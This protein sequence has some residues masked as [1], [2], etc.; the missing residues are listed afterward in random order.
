V[1]PSTGEELGQFVLDCLFN[2]FS[3]DY[4]QPEMI[5]TSKQSEM[6]MTSKQNVEVVEPS[7]GEELG[8]QETGELCFKGPQVMVE[9]L[10]NPEATLAT[11]KDGWC[12]T[13]DLGYYDQADVIAVFF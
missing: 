4:D 6:I 8:A 5:M 10:D 2:L 1:E 11:L 9:Y 3:S 13:G 7:T 12:H